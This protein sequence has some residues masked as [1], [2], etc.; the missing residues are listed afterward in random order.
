MFRELRLAF[1]SLRKQPGFT[2]VAVMTIALGVGAN[3]AIFSVVDAV[4]LRPLPF[5]DSDRVV[6]INEQTPTFPILSLSHE[7]YD[8]VCSQ[9]QSFSACGAFRNTTFNMSDGTEPRRVPGKQMTANMLSILGVT[10]AIGRTFTPAEDARGGEHVAMVSYAVW[11]ARFGGQAT[12]A[13]ERL[14]LDGTPYTVVGVL[15]AGFRLFQNAD[16]FLPLG[17]FLATQPPDRGWHP[18]IQPVARLKDGVSV[19]Q[20][21]TD[22]SGIATRL[23]KAYPQTNDKTSMMVTRA[24]DLL[25]QGVRTALLV[26]LGAVAGVLLIACLN[27]AGLLLARGLARR[28]DIAIRVAL[29]ASRAR[30]TG[31]VI[32]ESVVIGVAGGIAGLLLAAF[33]VPLL[34]SLVGP[35]L[36]RAD[37]VHV[38]ARVVLFTFGLALLTGVLCGLVPALQLAR[39]DVR[40][41]LNESGR[42]GA[43]GSPWQ[44][45]AR[46]F[47]VVAEIAMTVVLT[48]GAALLI[49]SFARLQDVL[50]G[51]D[52]ANTL[53]AEVPLSSV[54]YARDDVRTA[55]VDRLLERIAA[56]PG[57]RS[58][59]VTT[60]L[61]MSGGGSTIH[62]NIKGRAPAGPQQYTLA[63]YRAVTGRYLETM[64]IPLKK[65]RF[66]N[67][68]DREGS[69]RV[70][71]INETMARQH[72]GGEEPLGQH[73]QLGA[74]PDPDPQFPYMEVVGVVGDVRQQADA[75]ARSEMYVPYAQYPD[76]FLRRMYT[77]V[78][79]VVRTT[80][81]PAPFTAS[82][83]AT[84]REI[85]PDQPV[86]NV[87]T[88]DAVLSASVSQPR[89]RTLLLGVFAAIA[90]LLAGIGVYGLLAHGVAQRV[91]EFGVRMALGASPA[92]V[93]ALVLR[94]GLTL[95]A[96]GIAMGLVLTMGAVRA[97]NSVLFAIT[98]W[99]PVAWV[100]AA[101]T[102]F[103]VAVLASWLPA[104]RALRVDP[105]VALRA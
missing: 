49:R 39:V 14:L 47:L 52:A 18:G 51:F 15:P 2:L 60:F 31:H 65:G 55:T 25:V 61:P 29:G 99:D 5:H 77:N 36:P 1:R 81:A 58:A 19:Q 76:A 87:R 57:V 38:D 24:R 17:P 93:Q 102:L 21:N 23:E 91:T 9:A 98:P 30:V 88:L 46:A 70:I 56:L 4:M 44:R 72:F 6:V 13:G 32:A 11:E 78:N 53:A 35:T 73:I 12:V 90:L 64:G 3:S 22:I 85:D 27:V 74:E 16:V 10:P 100:G 83:R 40:G 20:A 62:F 67:D 34:L 48:I 43:G 95:A 104:H 8:D 33:S 105:A 89:F 68:R 101:A 54:K 79:L 84:V 42:G 80:S 63:G 82:I 59:G 103:F 7:N 86:A 96:I 41:T 92:R 71:A 37:T 75:E 28:R 26:L 69:P 50:P 66:L 94:Q 45:R 97:L